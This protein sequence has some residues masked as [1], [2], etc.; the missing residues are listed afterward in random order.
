MKIQKYRGYG[1]G[2]S[3]SGCQAR[4]VSLLV[5]SSSVAMEVLRLIMRDVILL[6][7][8]RLGYPVTLLVFQRVNQFELSVQ[9]DHE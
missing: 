7:L 2:M 5:C 6:N 4:R 9:S 8:Y 1:V 3:D